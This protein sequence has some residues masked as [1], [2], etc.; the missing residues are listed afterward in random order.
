MS[1]LEKNKP[2]SIPQEFT[3]LTNTAKAHIAYI[4]VCTRYNTQDVQNTVY[5]STL[6]KQTMI[7]P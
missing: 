3:L 4:I 5:Y 7:D 1:K 2:S 6:G